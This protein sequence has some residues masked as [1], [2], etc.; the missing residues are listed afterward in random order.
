MKR[1]M[2]VH[3]GQLSDSLA[4]TREVRGLGELIK[5][6]KAEYVPLELKNIHI[7][8]HQLFDDR[9]PE[10]WGAQEWYILAD[11]DTYENQCVGMCNFY[12]S[13]EPVEIDATN[14]IFHVECD[15]DF[16]SIVFIQ[17]Y[18]LCAKL[19]SMEN[20]TITVIQKENGES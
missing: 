3:R 5:A 8:K 19:L 13:S 10:E 14:K 15:L 6:V 20:P 12:E 18:G 2:R 11:F 1:L 7:D 4:T 9:L 16:S 17:G